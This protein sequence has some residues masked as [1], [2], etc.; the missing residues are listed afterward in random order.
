MLPLFMAPYIAALALQPTLTAQATTVQNKTYSS[1]RSLKTILI[2]CFDTIG[3]KLCVRNTATRKCIT[4]FSDSSLLIVASPRS[5]LSSSVRHY[6]VGRP[7]AVV[8]VKQRAQLEAASSRCLKCL[9]S[10][11]KPFLRSTWSWNFLTPPFTTFRTQ[12]LINK[13]CRLF[14]QKQA[15][16]LKM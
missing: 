9:L 16:I 8:H 3:R 1:Y 6:L 4:R 10:R 14:F 2:I 13:S 12:V 11:A 15:A 5:I 7:A